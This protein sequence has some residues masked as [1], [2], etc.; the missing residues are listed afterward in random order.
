MPRTRTPTPDNS[1]SDARG[2]ALSAFCFVIVSRKP[3]NPLSAKSGG[4][5][6]SPR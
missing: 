2:E 6:V 5:F 1:V 3:F 4:G